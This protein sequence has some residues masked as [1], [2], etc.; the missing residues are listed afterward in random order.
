MILLL[1][2]LEE[3][4]APV[5]SQRMGGEGARVPRVNSLMPLAAEPA[6]VTCSEQRSS[7]SGRGE[8]EGR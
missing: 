3:P 1:G 7:G 2:G 6:A 4:V 8:M 5:G